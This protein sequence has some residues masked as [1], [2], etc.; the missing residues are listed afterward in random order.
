[1][2][3]AD[4]PP[5][6]YDAN[7]H[8][9]GVTIDLN[10]H[11]GSG[12][13]A[14]GD[15]INGCPEVV[16]T[17]YNDLIW[18]DDNA[19]II[20]GGAGDDLLLGDDHPGYP[21]GK[22]TLNGGSGVNGL[23]GEYGADTLNCGG[24][25]GGWVDYFDSPG[26]VTVNL[27]L[28]TG[29]A[30][31]A[32][33][34]HITGCT[35][36]DGSDFGD[37][38]TG[39][40]NANAIQGGK[41][42]D[43]ISTVG[44]GQHDTIDCQAGNDTVDIDKDSI[45]HCE[46]I[47]GDNTVTTLLIHGFDPISGADN[48]HSLDCNAYWQNLQLGMRYVGYQGS[49]FTVGYYSTDTNCNI[50]LAFGDVNTSIDVLSQNLAAWI[51]AHLQNRPVNLVGYSMGGLIIKNM[52]DHL[53]ND[54]INYPG[55][56]NIKNVVTVDSPLAG[57]SVASACSATLGWKQCTQMSPNSGLI[58]YLVANDYVGKSGAD[59]TEIGSAAD[60]VVPGPG[61][62]APPNS[63]I[64]LPAQHKMVYGTPPGYG[65]VTNTAIDDDS[66][67]FDLP[68]FYADAN[69]LTQGWLAAPHGVLAIFLALVRT[70]W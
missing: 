52:I 67:S 54:V 62:C 14:S 50:N 47:I 9:L 2:T 1:V 6:G 19:N 37:T 30:S 40:N 28:G 21:D 56:L 68:L 53:G 25:G 42:D 55:S 70:D 12:A 7:G 10:Q 8:P 61:C 16:G 66:G 31:D 24:A 17:S 49:L 41:G 46:H 36:I 3:Y 38:L 57:S 32:D 11:Y 5:S 65:H 23:D 20:N 34:D 58:K 51:H 43:F 44:D 13:D 22:D 29:L 15:Q 59:V 33:G 45:K 39:D 35:G 69:G 63:Q 27:A 48:K 64:A 18:G 60:A 26:P 4:S